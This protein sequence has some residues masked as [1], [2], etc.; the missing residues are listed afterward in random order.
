[1]MTMARAV[2]F[3]ALL[4]ACGGSSVDTSPPVTYLHRKGITWELSTSGDD[5]MLKS[6]VVDACRPYDP[7]SN[8]WSYS[9]EPFYTKSPYASPYAACPSSAPSDIGNIDLWLSV[10]WTTDP[11]HFIGS[12]GLLADYDFARPVSTDGNGTATFKNVVR[13]I[14]QVGAF[15]DG[16]DGQ[17]IASVP[18][19][20]SLVDL[21]DSATDAPNQRVALGAKLDH[22]TSRGVSSAEAIF[23]IPAAKNRSIA[24][25]SSDFLRTACVCN[26]PVL[27]QMGVVCDQLIGS[28]QGWVPGRYGKD[29]NAA[30]SAP[31]SSGPAPNSAQGCVRACS[32]ADRTCSAACPGNGDDSPASISCRGECGNEYTACTTRCDRTNF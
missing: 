16:L 12:T 30:S 26:K 28:V 2:W 7:S 32:D 31:V 25:L 15:C 24:G 23:H 1:M 22:R 10:Q 11:D 27:V 14:A 18:A 3:V 20:S 5:L 4:G 21:E 9:N 6:Q 29:A 13:Q 19:K 8:R 17:V